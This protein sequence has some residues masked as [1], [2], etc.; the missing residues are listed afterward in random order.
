MT[1]M[2]DK[3]SFINR[4]S[5]G[6]IKCVGNLVGCSFK[7]ADE[8]AKELEKSQDDHYELIKDEKIFQIIQ[9]FNDKADRKFM[10]DKD[11]WDEVLNQLENMEDD[12]YETKKMIAN[13]I[14]TIKEKED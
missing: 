12:I 1:D 13:Y 5:N 9:Y 11:D 14:E 10:A 7:E 2:T 6:N 4:D 8:R 3:L